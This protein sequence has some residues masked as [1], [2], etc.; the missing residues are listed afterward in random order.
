M[1]NYINDISQTGKL[2]ITEINN[3]KIVLAI[4]YGDN[5]SHEILE[6]NKKMFQYFKTNVN[7]VRCNFPAVSHG[8]CIDDFIQKTINLADY[9]IFM[10]VDSYPLIEGLT[11]LIYSQIQSGLTLWGQA[12]TTSHINYCGTNKNLYVGPGCIGFSKSL[13]QAVG[14]PSFQ[15]NYRGDTAAE[16]SF[17]VKELGYNISFV[18]PRKTELPLWDLDIGIKFGMG[19]NFGGLF[20]HLMN[21]GDN[22]AQSIF[23]NECDKI[24]NAKRFTYKNIEGWFDFEKIYDRAVLEG[25]DGDIFVEI[26]S[27]LGKSSCYLGQKIKDSGKKIKLFCVDTFTGL[28]NDEAYKATFD[29]YGNDYSK[30]FLDN[31]KKCDLSDVIIPIQTTSAQASQL[32]QDQSIKFIYI[33]AN[34]NYDFIKADIENWYPKLKEDGIIGGHDYADYAIGVKRAVD[35]YFGDK[36]VKPIEGTTWVIYPEIKLEAIIICKDYSDYLNITLQQNKNQFD[37]IV[38]VTTINDLDTHDTVQKHQNGKI[39]CI[40]YDG[41]NKNGAKFNFGGARQFGLNN[42]KYNDTVVFLDADIVIKDNIKEK[43]IKNIDYT[44]FYG[45][46]RRFIPKVNDYQNLINNNIKPNQFDICEGSGCGFFQLISLKH[47]YIQK[48]GKNNLY[49][50]S[51]SAENCDIDFLKQFCPL[52]ENDPNLI[53]TGIE[54]WHLGPHGLH[55]DGRKDNDG[56]FN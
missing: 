34:H 28:E 42:L 5:R 12:Q 10:E 52:V 22:R 3:Q 31:V 43:I 15:P 53:R 27:F 29:K 56:F 55:N 35:E 30:V 18:Y 9:Y 20:Y 21:Q 37:N 40:N 11:N 51:F 26:G 8:F 45:S 17:R 25:N 1:Q 54:L 33:D 7:Y 24:L 50:D 32:F 4:F 41:F 44:K 49:K 47:P 19:N 16:F 14:S 46:Y 13:Y 2:L 39:Q 6:Y 23:V 36:T 48:Y 38:V